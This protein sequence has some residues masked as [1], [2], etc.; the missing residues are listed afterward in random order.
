[1][2]KDFKLS[3]KGAKALAFLQANHGEYTADELALELDMEARGVHTVLRP[4]VNNNLV[5]SETRDVPYLEED[6]KGTPTE[7]M[8]PTKTYA[9]TQDGLTF[10]I[11]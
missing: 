10:V 11:E 4:L 8:K 5:Y 1:M 2:T 7:V 6:E 3:E 9:V